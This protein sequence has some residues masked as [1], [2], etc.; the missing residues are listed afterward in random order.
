MASELWTDHGD[1]LTREVAC[2]SHPDAVATIVRL[3]HLFEAENHH[4]DLALSWRTLTLTLT[5]HDAGGTVTDRDH[6][7]ADAIDALLER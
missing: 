7:M 4:A 2:A 1:R 6:A 5:T 3:S